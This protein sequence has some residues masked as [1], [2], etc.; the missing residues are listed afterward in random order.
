MCEERTGTPAEEHARDHADF[1]AGQEAVTVLAGQ[2]RMGPVEQAAACG[3][4][5]DCNDCQQRHK[6]ARHSIN[7]LWLV[8]HANRDHDA[9]LEAAESRAMTAENL[10]GV[11]KRLL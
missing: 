5:V 4:A 7:E 10:I 2:V 6:C 11:I 1:V 3:Y 9:I 8:V